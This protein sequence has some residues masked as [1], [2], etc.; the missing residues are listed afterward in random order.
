MPMTAFRMNQTISDITKVNAPMMATMPRICV[1]RR[2]FAVV[3]AGQDHGD[4]APDAG[5]EVHRDGAD[6]V[7]DLQLVQHR[8]RQDHDHA[9]DGTDPE[10]AEERG[11][12]GSAVIDTRPA[13]APFSTMVRS[14][15]RT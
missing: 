9:T 14:A 11:R 6:H 2:G 8:N 15:C 1:P 13:S 5:E 10:R 4:G 12:S 3:A 7:V